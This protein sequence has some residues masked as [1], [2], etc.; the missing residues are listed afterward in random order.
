MQQLDREIENQKA[1]RP[2]Y[3]LAKMNSL[4]EHDICEK[5]YKASQAGVKVDLIVRGFCCLRP[6]VKGLSENIRV[7]SVVGRFLEHSRIFYFRNG[8]EDPVDG[9]F[10]IGSADWMYRNMMSR[11]EAV[12]PIEHQVGRERCW[13]ILQILLL[14]NRQAW[15][16]QP[17]GSYI[18]RNP[19]PGDEADGPEVVGTHTHLMNVTRQRL[20]P[21]S[22]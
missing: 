2:A 1:G 19:V 8:M 10:Y 13:K 12:A 18:Q 9:T 5:L 16:L 17:D 11:V 3:I 15:D 4:E 20:A 21:G 7:I 22:I 14:D 6:G